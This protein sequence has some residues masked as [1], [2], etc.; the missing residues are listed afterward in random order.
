MVTEA[1]VLEAASHFRLSAT[2][3]QARPLTGGL[4][5]ESWVVGERYVLQRLNAA[6]FVDLDAVMANLDVLSDVL[7]LP[8]RPVR[9]TTG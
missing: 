7:D 2:P 5:H 4:I 3:S 9:T 8:T 6:V 1:E